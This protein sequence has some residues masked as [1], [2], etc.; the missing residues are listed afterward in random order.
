MALSVLMRNSSGKKDWRD[1]K[2]GMFCIV[3]RWLV[4]FLA[5][6]V[7]MYICQT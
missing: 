2:D 4:G 5:R 1:S 6:C 3:L 7:C